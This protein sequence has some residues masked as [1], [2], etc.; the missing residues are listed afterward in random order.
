MLISKTFLGG[1]SGKEP[2]GQ[3]GRHKRR[4]FHPCVGKVPWR[5]TWQPTSE[6]LPGESHGQRSLG[7]YSP[8]GRR[9]GH[10]RRNAAR[11]HKGGLFCFCSKDVQGQTVAGCGP[12]S[13]C[14]P[15][16]PRSYRPLLSLYAG[17]FYFRVAAQLLQH[18]PSCLS[19]RQEEGGS[20]VPIQPCFSLSGRDFPRS[21][22]FSR[23]RPCIGHH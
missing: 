11:K 14:P 22:P 18:Q 5:R 13:G 6:I 19:S 3:C 21:P 23:H 15:Q 8:K 1:A 10:D 7:G 17:L 16:G 2:A 9:V 4:R 20:Y 12:V